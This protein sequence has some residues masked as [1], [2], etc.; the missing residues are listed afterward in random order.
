MPSDP[1]LQA[2]AFKRQE[3]RPWMA[4]W[5]R[6][7]LVAVAVATGPLFLCLGLWLGLMYWVEDIQE[8]RYIDD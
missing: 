6:C 3:L 8:M 7:L 2:L 5:P 1:D 4:R